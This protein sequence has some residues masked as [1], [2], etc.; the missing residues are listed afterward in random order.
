VNQNRF[1]VDVPN[2]Q[3]M[4]DDRKHD[5]RAAPDPIRAPVVYV[6]VKE[7]VESDLRGTHSSL[8]PDS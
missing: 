6:I 4:H 3:D 7:K 2:A 8:S 1:L 5:Q